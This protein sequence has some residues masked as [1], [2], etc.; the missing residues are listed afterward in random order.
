MTR[1]GVDQA[2]DPVRADFL[3]REQDDVHGVNLSGRA[4]SS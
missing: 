4:R 1:T 2:D 3:A